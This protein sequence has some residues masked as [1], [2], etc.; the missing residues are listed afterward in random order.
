VQC[1]HGAD[2]VQQAVHHRFDVSIG[3]AAE[4]ATVIVDGVIV[5]D[6]AHEVGITSI[7]PAAVGTQP[8]YRS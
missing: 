1:V 7:D 3:G 6:R 5:V 2:E 8:T 4:G